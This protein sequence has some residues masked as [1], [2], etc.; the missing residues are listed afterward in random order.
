MGLSP[1]A[2]INERVDRIEA[3]Q[4][5]YMENKYLQDNKLTIGLFSDNLNKT[6]LQ[7]DAII[8]SAL[9]QTKEYFNTTYQKC[10]LSTADISAI[11][12]EANPSFKAKI[13]KELPNYDK[14]QR[15]TKDGRTVTKKFVS[16]CDKLS[17]CMVDQKNLK[18][19][20]T[21]QE[22]GDIINEFYQKSET[23]RRQGE[24][25]QMANLGANKYINGDIADSDYD[26]MYDM[27]QVG[28]ILYKSY[29]PQPQIIFYNPPIFSNKASNS[30]NSGNAGSPPAAQKNG[31]RTTQ[32]TQAS[33]DGKNDVA[34]SQ[35]NRSGNFGGA[36][37]Q[38]AQNAHAPTPITEDEELN[39]FVYKRSA[40]STLGNYDKVLFQNQC[41]LVPKESQK[42]GSQTARGTGTPEEQKRAH[43]EQQAVQKALEAYR[44]SAGLP[45]KEEAGSGNNQAASST[46][47]NNIPDEE[48]QLDEIMNKIKECST[49]CEDL[50]YDE[51]YT[52]IMQCACSDYISPALAKDSK[53]PVLKE[54]ALIVR[55]CSVA[56][57]MTVP[58]TSA[59]NIL[60]IA[61][62]FDE[63]AMS[64][65]TLYNEGKLN[66]KQQKKELL[67]SSIP[68]SDIS[69][70]VAFTTTVATKTPPQE[71]SETEK[72]T[73][74]ELLKSHLQG[75]IYGIDRNSFVL[76]DNYE[77]EKKSSSITAPEVASTP[78]VQSASQFR[79]AD[80]VTSALEN[81]SLLKENTVAS[82][83]LAIF[84][85]IEKNNQLMDTIKE[86]V[87][88]LKSSTQLLNSKKQSN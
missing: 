68:K 85:R 56:S 25:I 36:G 45:K 74:I 87:S 62:L 86:V 32:G 79:D 8:S 64:V 40:H 50:P 82:M 83:N 71:P 34:S 4:K 7:K 27:S 69:K 67:S 9:E 77:A 70:S 12:F 17:L 19:R 53:Q 78:V 26:L 35:A 39:D 59:K 42:T 13:E 37:N 75:S 31:M 16:A 73:E 11:L 52:C 1:M 57:S 3:R 33:T 24:D 5:N 38:L 14:S 81:Q 72:K 49:K 55:F 80:T 61:E 63:I 15:D 84:E 88:E 76:L 30:E 60:S 21:A 6:Q 66:V 43:Q 29:K 51:K 2:G 41:I 54:G 44:A 28:T 48:K 22:C 23:S 18:N 46:G 10:D 20:F 58:N 65:S 47:S